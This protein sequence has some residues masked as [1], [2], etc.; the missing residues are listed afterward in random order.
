VSPTLLKS[1][2]PHYVYY[3]GRNSLALT[4]AIGHNNITG[5]RPEVAEIPISPGKSYRIFM[6]SDGVFDMLMPSEQE[7]FSLYKSC[8]EVITF[9][10]ERWKQ[11]WDQ[12]DSNDLT[13][14]LGRTFQFNNP[15][16]FDDLSVAIAEIVPI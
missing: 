12:A 16:H 2:S 4:Q 10:E 7:T 1:T 9:A 6:A 5:L 11:I 8:D 13:K 15:E 3:P 14:G